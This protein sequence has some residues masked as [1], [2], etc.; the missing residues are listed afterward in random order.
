[1]PDPTRIEKVKDVSPGLLAT[2]G[3][4]SGHLVPGRPQER[5]IGLTVL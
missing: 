1:M 5:S 4:E 3:A 2:T